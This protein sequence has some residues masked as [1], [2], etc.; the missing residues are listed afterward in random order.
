MLSRMKTWARRL[1]RDGHAIYLASR[2]PRVPWYAKFLAIAVA[3]YALSPIDLIP[4]FIPVVGY[5]DD[6][7][8][9]PFGIWLVVRLIPEEIMV[10]YRTMANEAG[11][12]P[13]TRAGMVAIIS[14][15][16]F[17]GIDAGLDR[18]CPLG[19]AK[20]ERETDL[21]SVTCISAMVHKLTSRGLLL[22]PLCGDVSRLWSASP[23]RD[24]LPERRLALP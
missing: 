20:L 1:N 14:L 10:K 18:P 24:G 9:V 19:P 4:D 8:I 15:W 2:D 21:A 12:R 17:G 3:G 7:I 22:L 5:L 11:Q 6:L 23:R 16:I 13:V